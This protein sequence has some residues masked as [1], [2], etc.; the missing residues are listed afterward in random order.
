MPNYSLFGPYF[1]FW[2]GI[3]TFMGVAMTRPRPLTHVHV[4]S[5]AQLVAW[6]IHSRFQSGWSF[7]QLSIVKTTSSGFDSGKTTS[8]T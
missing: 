2:A 6:N 1:G 4:I 5:N 3:M 8:I 7:D